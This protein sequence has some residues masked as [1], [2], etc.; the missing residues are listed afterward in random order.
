MV[1]CY[2]YLRI[3]ISIN[4][5][6]KLEVD[7]IGW[8]CRPGCM[9]SKVRMRGHWMICSMQRRILLASRIRM[10]LQFNVPRKTQVTGAFTSCSQESNW[11]MSSFTWTKGCFK[12]SSRPIQPPSTAGEPMSNAKR[13][14]TQDCHRWAG[15]EAQELV[16][17]TW[18][19]SEFV[20]I[21]K[22][23]QS[24]DITKVMMMK[25]DECTLFNMFSIVVLLEFA[26]ADVVMEHAHFFRFT[27]AGEDRD[28]DSRI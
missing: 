10:G 2:N 4:I 22:Q 25:T 24:N 5:H 14:K 28:L 19:S 21:E 12:K 23:R 26:A 27:A 1:T 13:S 17:G 7:W 16:E 3:R 11:L 8:C 15:Q 20:A 6:W 18:N 9:E